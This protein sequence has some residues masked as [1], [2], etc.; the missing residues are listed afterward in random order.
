M[1][2]DLNITLVK[3]VLGHGNLGNV[4]NNEWKA[5]EWEKGEQKQKVWKIV[6]KKLNGIKG[7]QI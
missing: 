6:G 2:S 4:S 5:I 7:R 1:H 3:L